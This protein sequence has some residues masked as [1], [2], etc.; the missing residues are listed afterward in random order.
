VW[1]LFGKNRCY[2]P[3]WKKEDSRVSNGYVCFVHD[4]GHGLHLLNKILNLQVPEEVQCTL[5]SWLTVRILSIISIRAII[6]L[7]PKNKNAI[8]QP[9]CRSEIEVLK[10]KVHLIR[11]LQIMCRDALT[12]HYIC[13]ATHWADETVVS[14]TLSWRYNCVATHSADEIIVSRHTELTS[15][16]ARCVASTFSIHKHIPLPNTNVF[17]ALT[18]AEQKNNL[19]L[20]VYIYIYIYSYYS[21][22]MH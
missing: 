14:W 4:K 10:C 12:W 9:Q 1:F 22:L 5:S 3:A 15:E 7:F 8:L 2:R 21:P 6:V 17:I 13:V 18:I 19:V 20:K 11:D 16:V